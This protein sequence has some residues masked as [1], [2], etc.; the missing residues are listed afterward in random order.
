[1]QRKTFGLFA[2]VMGLFLLLYVGL[3]YAFQFYS[4]PSRTKL[5]ETWKDSIP[6]I[7][8][9]A[10]TFL[11]YAWQRRQSYQAGIRDFHGQASKQV[12]AAIDYVMDAN[13]TPADYRRVSN[14]LAIL[15]DSMRGVYRDLYLRLSRG[16]RFE[17]YNPLKEIQ[18]LL[19]AFGDL[20]RSI[21]SRV[22]TKERIADV[23]NMTQ[24]A[25]AR[26]LDCAYLWPDFNGFGKIRDDARV[27]VQ[28][29]R[30]SKS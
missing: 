4:D 11:T 20:D 7:I 28:N 24:T 6:L 5:L 16:A 25:M 12:H 22:V 10:G 9:F 2:G 17:K 23:W 14:D 30:G 15:R 29:L 21:E 1:M 26:E 19:D 13:S 18:D 27:Q 8:A 3:G